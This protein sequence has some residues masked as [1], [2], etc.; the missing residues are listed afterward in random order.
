MGTA[1]AVEYSWD[2]MLADLGRLVGHLQSLEFFLRTFLFIEQ[3]LP[4]MKNMDAVVVGE[5]LDENPMTDWR[6]LRQL[7]KDYNAV[8][9]PKAR[10]KSPGG[11]YSP[12]IATAAVRASRIASSASPGWLHLGCLRACS[13]QQLRCGSGQIREALLKL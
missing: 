11:A 13:D 6:Q 3:G 7:V 2:E 5:T 8:I 1:T 12:P 4:F 10:K 9:G